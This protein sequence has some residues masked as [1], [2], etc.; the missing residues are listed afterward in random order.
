MKQKWHKQKNVGSAREAFCFVEC[1]VSS[2]QSTSLEC[3]LYLSVNFYSVSQ[4]SAF[5]LSLKPF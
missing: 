1:L 2:C 5:F 4:K 3:F